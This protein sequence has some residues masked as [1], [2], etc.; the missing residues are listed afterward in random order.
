MHAPLAFPA[1]PSE[2][3]NLPS[4]PSGAVTAYTIVKSAYDHG[5]KRC[6][7]SCT[8]PFRLQVARERLLDQQLMVV[9]ISYDGGSEQWLQE[10]AAAM[11]A[12]EHDLAEAQE[13]AEGRS[14]KSHSHR[15][16]S[17]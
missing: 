6:L 10:C 8:E 4:W 5:V 1:L 7:E 16:N 2:P 9:G 3:E 17:D 13:Y 14:A 11:V 15:G 12:L